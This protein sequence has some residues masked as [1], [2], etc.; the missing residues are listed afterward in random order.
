MMLR[1]IRLRIRYYCRKAVV[2]IGL[3]PDCWGRLNYT[4]TTGRA[5]CPGCG[6]AK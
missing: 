2:A 4:T 1:I 5:I 6:R 3:C